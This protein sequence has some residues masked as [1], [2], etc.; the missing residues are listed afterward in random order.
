MIIDII[1]ILVILI[2]AGIGYK[3]GLAKILIKL[4]GFVVAIALAFMFKETVA[5]FLMSNTELSNDINATI[6][7]GLTTEISS[8]G[9]QNAFY[10]TMIEKFGVN[11]KIEELAKT[12]TKFIFE[13]IAFVIIVITVI[14]VAWILQIVS[15]LVF[16]LPLIG[17]VNSLGGLIAGGLLNII[18]IFILFAILQ[19]LA[20]TVPTIQQTING[21]TITKHLYNNNI[22]TDVLSNKLNIN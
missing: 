4:I 13:S 3:K 17:T 16:S 19:L 2:G 18:R 20:P 10:T 5:S 8:E 22:V 15:D 6:T 12:I 7:N 9:E 11:T 1:L 14:I 21:T